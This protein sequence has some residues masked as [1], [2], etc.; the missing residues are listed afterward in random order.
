M[1]PPGEPPSGG[2]DAG[3]SA[4]GGRPHKAWWRRPAALVALG[5]AVA[6]A[7]VLPI[8]LTGSGTSQAVALQTADST[9]P[10]PFTPDTQS[11]PT[12]GA[13]ATAS[14]GQAATQAAGTPTRTVPGSAVGLY[15]GTESLSSCDV[16][17]LS[18]YLTTH[19]DK[20]RAWASVEGI[21]QDRIAAYLRTLTP[22]VLRAD[23]RVTNHG[24]QNGQAT[25]FQSVLQSGT[26]V[27][28]DSS[29]LPRARCACGNPLLAP[30]RSGSQ[31]TFTGTAWPTFQVNN[32]VIIES[33]A[34]QQTTI[35]LFDQQHDRWFSRPVG[36]DGQG[37]RRVPAPPLPSTSASGS[38]SSSTTSGRPSASTS[39][40][41]SSASPSPS[42]QSPSSSGSPSGSGSASVPGS[43][44]ASGSA[45]SGSPSGS[46]P[47]PANVPSDSGFGSLSS[48]P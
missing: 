44:S 6:A 40:S 42:T 23:T 2:G 8:V 9:G 10:Y 33:T 28:I 36:G 14:A 11:K 37:D 7:V 21:T 27:L 18:A 25:A 13:S 35:I 1:P 31:E 38:R 26:A 45:S 20:G 29:G 24:F 39:A 12:A 34:I 43:V 15:G 3:S 47:G 48:S 17:R 4:A 19:Q 5:A 41:P 22:V 32:I 16:A 46:E 30:D